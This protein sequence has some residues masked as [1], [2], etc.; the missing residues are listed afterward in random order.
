VDDLDGAVAG[1]SFWVGGETGSV[2]TV[3]T[4]VGTIEVRWD[5]TVREWT[6]ELGAVWTVPSRVGGRWLSL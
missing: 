4:W 1:E 5:N 6:Q 3:V 2:P